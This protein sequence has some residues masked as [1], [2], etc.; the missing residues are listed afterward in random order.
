V[1][2][3]TDGPLIG[4]EIGSGQHRRLFADPKARSFRQGYGRAA[5]RSGR[6][7]LRMGVARNRVVAINLDARAS[8]GHGER[9]CMSAHL[10]V[11]A[12]VRIERKRDQDDAGGRES[13][14][15]LAFASP[16]L[17]PDHCPDEAHER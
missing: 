12:D 8:G 14:Q 1:E 9:F 11:C 7:M 6:A 13:R 16:V 15:P 17:P 2:W 4:K 3:R 5:A 10:S